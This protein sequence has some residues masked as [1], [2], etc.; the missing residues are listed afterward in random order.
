[1]YS[2]HSQAGEWNDVTCDSQ[3]GFICEIRAEQSIPT[4]VCYNLDGVVILQYS[5]NS[6]SKSCFTV[7]VIFCEPL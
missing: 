7:D 4:Q 5:L 3:Y 1:M 2:F 6:V